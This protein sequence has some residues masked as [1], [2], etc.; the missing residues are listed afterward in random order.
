[1]K[2]R[3][4]KAVSIKYTQNDFAPKITAKGKNKIAEEILKLAKENDIPIYEDRDL[5]E[6]LYTMDVGYEIP[7]TLYKAIAEI[8]TFV[9][10]ANEKY[11]YMIKESG[12]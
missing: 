3:Q 11:K 8:L 10:L 5:I 1:M 6:I 2:D 4:K 9:Y 12:E 7:E